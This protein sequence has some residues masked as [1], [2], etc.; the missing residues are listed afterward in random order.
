MKPFGCYFY[1]RSDGTPYYVGKGYYHRALAKTHSV[2]LPKDPTYILFQEFLNEE[3]A[4]EAERFFINFFGRKDLGTGCLRNLTDGGDGRANPSE[5]AR[6]KMRESLKSRAVMCR[7]G[8]KHTEASRQKMS[9][10]AKRRGVSDATWQANLGN[11][12]F[13]GHQHSEATRQKM[14]KAATGRSPSAATRQ[15]MSAA[16]TGRPL[17]DEHRQKLKDAHARR[18]K[19]EGKI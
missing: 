12:Y 5:T 8:C 3:E 9:E 11:T 14:S 19:V 2:P 4:F 13:L 10:V 7:L 18:K 1:L 16:K 17:S 15:K 6:Q